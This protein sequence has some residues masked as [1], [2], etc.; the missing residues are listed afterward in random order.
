[1]VLFTEDKEHNELAEHDD[2]QPETNNTEKELSVHSTFPDEKTVRFNSHEK[3]LVTE[4]EAEAG[5]IS[6][7]PPYQS[8]DSSTTGQSS[9]GMRSTGLIPAES[10]PNIKPDLDPITRN[11]SQANDGKEVYVAGSSTAHSPP[12]SARRQAS[13]SY[14]EY[15][16]YNA[17]AMT[18]LI[19][20]DPDQLV[21]YFA[22][23]SLFAKSM[24][25]V[26]LRDILGGGFD[27]LARKGSSLGL[28]EA[29]A[30]PIVGVADS[31]PSS[32]HI[33]L[34]LGDPGQPES[35]AWIVMRNVHEDLKA[36]SEKYDMIV[37]RPSQQD[38]SYSWI[39]G[40]VKD[41]EPGLD[42]SSKEQFRLLS[43]DEVVA[44]F[45]N[46]A[47]TSIRKRGILRVY[48]A[49]GMEEILLLIFLSCAA[50][51]ERQRRRKVKKSLLFGL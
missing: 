32:K 37:S 7:L 27:D 51:C 28:K 30:A 17:N 10:S 15:S 47:L 8:A 21:L 42:K 2:K 46:A 19:I 41:N 23:V 39:R 25:D 36:G 18:H 35:Q 50:L 48:D 33:K 16:F 9:S 12:V 31:M 1:M 14:R 34:G 22:E 20:C 5:T 4:P 45:R 3:A 26:C 29:A 11:M 6:S 38:F 13:K 40:A 44:S 43:G 24:P 49:P